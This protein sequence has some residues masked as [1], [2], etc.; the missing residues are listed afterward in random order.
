LATNY[1]EAA[2]L[3][4]YGRPDGLPRVLCGQNQYF[5]WGI[6]QTD[7]RV[8]VHVNGDPNRWRRACASVV[9]AATFGNPYAMP[10]EKDR[11]IFICR[12]LR[13][14]LS[15]IWDRLRRYE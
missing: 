2:A 4:F 5:L 13:R 11:P 15:E 9:V 12:G 14:P 6:R 3:D 8:I 7:D 1:G 10:Y